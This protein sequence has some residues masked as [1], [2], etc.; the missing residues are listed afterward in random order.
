[1]KRIVVTIAVNLF[2]CCFANAKDSL[3]GLGDNG[4]IAINLFEHR[5]SG[6][7]RLIDVT[8]IM[9]GWFLAG[10]VKE[11]SDGHVEDRPIRLA[12]K[13]AS[14]EGTISV[15]FGE[16][17]SEIKLKGKLTLGHS[18]FALDESIDCKMMVGL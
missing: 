13:N 7:S 3:W 1:M 15:K 6:S 12:A 2:L 4:K 10:S 11:P 14:F 5:S 18:P 17:T 16:D 8:L 9:G